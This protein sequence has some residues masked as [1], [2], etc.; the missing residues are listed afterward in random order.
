MADSGGIID[1]NGDPG[2]DGAR[3][4]ARLTLVL[5]VAA[6]LTVAATAVPILIGAER[7]VAWLGGWVSGYDVEVKGSADL[8]FWDIP[9]ID[10]DDVVLRLPG[11]RFVPVDSPPVLRIA[12]LEAD[13]NLWALLRGSVEARRLVL[14]RPSLR[15]DRATDGTDNWS[16]RGK[17]RLNG[18]APSRPGTPAFSLPSW[19]GA[20][21]SALRIEGGVIRYTD[22]RLDRDITLDGISLDA[23]AG[24]SA[25]G[26]VLRLRGDGSLRS[27]PVYMEAELR[28]LE[29]FRDGIRV[30]FQMTLDAAPGS[31]AMRGSVA[32]RGRWAFGVDIDLDL[33]D[34]QAV[35]AA[36]PPAPVDLL[37]R[38]SARV[39][40]DLKGGRLGLT[41]RTLVMGATDL[42]GKVEAD[43]DDKLP[44]VELDLEAGSL[45]LRHA[46][47]ALR[48]AGLFAPDGQAAK[49]RRFVV[50]G[51]GR[52]KWARLTA[53]GIDLGAGALGLSW[54]TGEPNLAA[55]AGAMSLF[56]G[57]VS[58]RA[59]ATANE[60]K[61]ALSL[62]LS[63]SD[64][65]AALMSASLLGGHGVGGRLHGSA[66]VLAVGATPEELLA[67]V[68]GGGR[69][70]LSEGRIFGS[71]LQRAV[72][73]EKRAIGLSRASMDF[74]VEG[75]LVA[76]DSVLLDFEVGHT[77][78]AMSWDMP[79][80]DLTV[81]FKPSP[82]FEGR[83]GPPVVTGPMWDV[84]LAR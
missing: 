50:G 34:P 75:G 8:R 3:P 74:T 56:G 48:M 36:W 59:E 80:G 26:K 12:R 38:A 65:D 6:A 17:P 42:A 18:E 66:E 2:S 60:G 83:D 69:M 33:D 62:S 14:V 28:R 57:T 47:A 16:L 25:D 71:A 76:S 7:M 23:A 10:A 15:L 1:D 22:A 78:A 73:Q 53:P 20:E 41:L 30:P 61:T 5:A 55:E 4:L 49:T 29:D 68:G 13:L 63:G 79:S 82:V 46:A 54:R 45:D 40:A 24:P 39:R 19:P 51:R 81:R 44:L 27:E 58:A 35:A 32:H 77:E 21:I 70:T 9:G 84:L 37:G 43:F 67:A 72:D 11:D 64:L 52:I 31:L